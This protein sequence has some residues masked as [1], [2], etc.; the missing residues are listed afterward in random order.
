MRGFEILCE[1][2]RFQTSMGVLFFFYGTKGDDRRS[3]VSVS[4]NPN[5]SLFPTYTSHYKNGKEKYFRVCEV[6]DCLEA[7]VTVNVERKFPLRWTSNLAFVI[8]YDFE[9]PAN[10]ENDVVIFLKRM[11][12]LNI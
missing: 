9:K 6:K 5:R 4:V 1:G 10:Y 7:T 3:W 11:L 2:L 8:G 12:P